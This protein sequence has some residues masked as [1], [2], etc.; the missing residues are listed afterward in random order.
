MRDGPML[1]SGLERLARGEPG[2]L[3][4]VFESA[5]DGLI[6]QARTVMGNVANS[7]DAASLVHS[8]LIPLMS[9]SV[10]EEEIR[11]LKFE[12]PAQFFAFT[13]RVLRNKLV[14]RFRRRGATKRGGA[15]T[16]VSI[17]GDDIPSELQA[18]DYFDLHEALEELRSLDQRLWVVV[19]NKFLARMTNGE[20]ARALNLSEKSIEKDWTFARAWLARRLGGLHESGQI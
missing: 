10:D 17:T 2:A 3:N 14:D 13:S 8:A 16:T 19:E 15:E 18:V 11:D 20:V 1:E 6:R 5:Y 9:D 7:S 4:D 12:G